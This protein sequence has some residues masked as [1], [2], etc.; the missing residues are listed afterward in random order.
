MRAFSDGD[1]GIFLD[2]RFSPLRGLR[3]DIINRRIKV[4]AIFEPFSFLRFKF[5]R[6]VIVA[7]I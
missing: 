1:K 3:P 2:I 5:D 6:K 4:L 7:Y